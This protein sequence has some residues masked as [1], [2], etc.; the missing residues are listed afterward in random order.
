MQ[1]NEQLAAFSTQVAASVFTRL[2]R[3][4][5]GRDFGDP[6]VAAV[7]MLAFIERVPYSVYT[8]GF[9][10][11]TEAIESMVTVIRRGYLALAD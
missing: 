6:L 10:T 2:L 1:T 9:V 8:L 3:I 4:L 5:E 11:E 7:T